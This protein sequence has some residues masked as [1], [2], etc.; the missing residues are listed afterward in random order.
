[1][2]ASILDQFIGNKVM[3]I[4]DVMLDKYLTGRIDRISPEAPVPIVNL[5]SRET[6]LGGAANVTLSLKALEAIPVLFSVIGDDANGS[7]LI[8]LLA[9]HNISQDHLYKSPD[10]RTTVK[11]RILA[12]DQQILRVDEEDTHALSELEESKLINNI[13]E[14]LNKELVSVI[15]L[16]DYNKGVLTPNV[17][18]TVIKA[19]RDMNIPTVVDP[20]KDNF[21]CYQGVTCF[22][23][24]L[25]EVREALNREIPLDNYSLELVHADL[26]TKLNHEISL[27]TLS[28]HGVFSAKDEE[29]HWIPTQAREIA[30]VCG[31]GD[32]VVATVALCIAHDINI[33]KMCILANMTGGQVC[34]RVGV[35][36]VDKAQLCLEIST[37]A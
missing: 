19:A 6:R 18:K 9:D 32:A 22:K 12:S 21:W 2:N 8:S 4:G 13:L 33:K 37:N 29:I 30:D 16:Q 15:I 25:K 11:S 28:E 27:I 35:V 5:K 3:V 1:M 10:R 17:I 24:N 34:E 31:A 36:P 26:K 14:Y 7:L 23:P 20:K